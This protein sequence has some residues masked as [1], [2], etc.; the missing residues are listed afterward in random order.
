MGS[1]KIEDAY[2]EFIN[3]ENI[4]YSVNKV[5]IR[6]IKNYPQLLEL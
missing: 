2:S 5:L 3:L 6:I 4:Y 1:R